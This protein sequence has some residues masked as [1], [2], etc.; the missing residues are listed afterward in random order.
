MSF[1]SYDL[2]QLAQ[3]FGQTLTLRKSTSQGT[4]NP[5]TGTLSGG[6]TTDY[7]ITGYFFSY[8]EGLATDNVTRSTRRCLI[9]ALGLAVEPDDEDE[10]LGVGDT[11]HIIR[12]TTMYSGTTKLGYVCEVAD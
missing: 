12:V 3:D 2:F 11:V 6:T 4:Y 9:P 10:I 8:S 1:R 7:E 5:A